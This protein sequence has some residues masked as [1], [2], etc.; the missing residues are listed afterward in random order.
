MKLGGSLLAGS[1]SASNV[2]FS[3]LFKTSKMGVES[4][5]QVIDF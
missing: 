3:A 1:F 4:C 2:V 5:W